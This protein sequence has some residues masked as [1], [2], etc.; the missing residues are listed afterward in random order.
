MSGTHSVVKAET[1]KTR[2]A[3]I[4]A[5]VE[6]KNA[7]IAKLVAQRDALQEV[8][9]DCTEVPADAIDNGKPK[10]QRTRGVTLAIERAIEQHTPQIE[11]LIELV[12][13]EVKGA[14]PRI[15]KNN[16]ANMIRERRVKEENGVYALMGKGGDGTP[17]AA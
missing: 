9:K 8:L 17:E 6:G 7:E 3:A 2:I 10:R 14:T 11:R 15:V 1:I 5:E 12:Q 13:I 4:N 16:L